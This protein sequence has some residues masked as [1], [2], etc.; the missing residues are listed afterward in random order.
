MAVGAVT[1]AGEV[2]IWQDEFDGDGLPDASKWRYDVG[3]DGWGNNEAQFYT[4]ARMENARVEDG[5]LIIEARKEPW[6]S[7]RSA[8]ND[9]TSARLVTKGFGDW[10]YGR[11]EVRAKMPAG[12][13]TW[14][15]IWMLPTSGQY[16]TWPRGGEIDIM[17]HVGYDMGTVHGSLHSLANNWLTETQP[18]GSVEV[19]TVDT[20]FHIYAVEWESDQITFMV[21][22]EPYFS[23][24]NPGTGWEAWPFDQP[25]HLILNLAVG[26]FW[27]G[28]EGI[29]PDI[30]PAR[31]EVDYVRVY[32]LGETEVLD[33]DGDG[34]PNTT[35]PDDDGDGL[36]DAE[37]HALGTD[38]LRVDTDGDGFSDAEEVEAG[39]FPLLAGSYPG[40]DASILLIN[41]D[42]AFGEEPWI[43]HT[44]FLDAAG[45]WTGQ[46]GSWGGAYSIF[47]YVTTGLETITFSNYREGDS[48]RAE[49][50]L[51]QEWNPETMDL[52]PGDTVRF[53]GR[54]FA[55]A[56]PE[57]VTTKAFIRVLDFSFQG[58]P[59]SVEAEISG[60][61]APF[62]LETVLG[63]EPFNVIQ[64]GF[65]ITAPQTDT[66]AI[67]F[68][69][70][71]A[72]LNE[73]M[74]WGNWPMVDGN[75]DTGD[76]MGWLNVDRDPYIWSYALLNWI[77]LPEPPTG[78]NGSWVFVP[79]ASR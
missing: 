27:G 41:N 43:M 14:P 6:P 51:Y 23:Y 54:A 65:M 8:R 19:L 2:L 70:L 25:F 40:S 26:G 5:L 36:T 39:T 72:T 77:Y 60:E 69:G 48:A 7:P 61:E 78:G 44:N 17:E 29:D 71:E 15:A 75:V 50:L 12:R 24:Q 53:R 68:S 67:T 34:E 57:G 52:L 35:D 63:D 32:D 56:P 64:V 47:D 22:G 11:I 16:G 3:G 33:T 58:M 74:E 46:S 55:E 4:E 37:E 13:G 18:T 21:D 62:E 10:L 38:L 28:R 49:H 76:W 45:T 30:W 1:A 59:E 42:F 31:M 73:R 20:D 9:Y 79:G 66:A